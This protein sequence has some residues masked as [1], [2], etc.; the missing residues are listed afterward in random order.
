MILKKFFI[1]LLTFFE[2]AYILFSK[3]V[4]FLKSDIEIAQDTELLNI[5]EIAKS[6]GIDEKYVEQYG[7][8]K[9]KI[10]LSII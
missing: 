9:A 8:Y 5:N 7:K 6:A 3:D 1:I 4:V 10:D 2:N